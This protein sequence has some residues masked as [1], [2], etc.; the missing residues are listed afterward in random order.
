MRQ[1]DIWQQMTQDATWHHVLIFKQ[2]LLEDL[3]YFFVFLYSI[4]NTYLIYKQN[5]NTREEAST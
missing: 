2:K 4:W 5:S 1:N 3:K